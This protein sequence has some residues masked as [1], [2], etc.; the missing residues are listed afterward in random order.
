GLFDVSHMAEFFITGKD[1]LEMLQLIFTNDFT[2]MKAGRVRYTLLCN[3]AGGIIDDLVVCKLDEGR[4][5]LVVNAANREKDAAW[6]R[7]HLSGSCVFEDVSDN[8]AQIALQGPASLSILESVSKTIPDKYYTMIEGGLAAKIPCRISRTGYTG[9]DG[10]EL[11]CNNENAVLLWKRLLDAGKDRG[12]IPCGLGSRDTLRLEAGMPLWGH[13]MDE[14][15][16]PFEAGLSFAVKMGKSDFIGRNSLLEKTEPGRLRTGIEITGRG[17]VRE[18]EA[19][20]HGGRQIGIT[21]SGTF[22]PY[23]AKSCAMAFLDI[24]FSKPGI[25]IEADVRGRMIEGISCS[26]PFYTRKT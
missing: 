20:F 22:C 4:Y 16:T 8:W 9:E 5:M 1:A 17:I 10:F 11:Y 26:L 6:I 13:E 24:N 19:V 25:I 3:E 21:T 18:K 23:L 12:L 7:G 14:T 2:N 15:V